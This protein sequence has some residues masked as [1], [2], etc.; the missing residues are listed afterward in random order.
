M[1]EGDEKKAIEHTSHCAQL[2]SLAKNSGKT[3]CAICWRSFAKESARDHFYSVGHAQ[4][5]ARG[6]ANKDNYNAVWIMKNGVSFVKPKDPERFEALPYGVM[7]YAQ[8]LQNLNAAFDFQRDAVVRLVEQLLS[9]VRA[10]KNNVGT[11]N[12]SLSADS[13]LVV[14]LRNLINFATIGFLPCSNHSP[15]NLYSPDN[16][17]SAMQKILETSAPRLCDTKICGECKVCSNKMKAI[18]YPS[19]LSEALDKIAQ[20]ITGESIRAPQEDHEMGESEQKKLKS[21]NGK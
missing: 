19:K 12:A 14:A 20:T 3:F 16:V 4:C 8:R 18:V 15:R 11:A 5:E 2:P 17:L 1:Y 13:P 7:D 21:D 9:S 10:A 6:A